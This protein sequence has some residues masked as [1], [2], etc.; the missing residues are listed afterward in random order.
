MRKIITI[1]LFIFWSTI[2]Y[3]LEEDYTKFWC[4]Q[5]KGMVEV[6]LA[7]AT[8]CDCLTTTHSIEVDYANKFYE[9][10][11]QSLHYSIMTKKLPGI[12]LLIKDT[13]DNVY[14]ARLKNIIIK[15]KLPITVWTLKINK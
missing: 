1:L 15:Y 2:S 6:K 13:G 12:L 9:A 3:A 7:D 5:Q 11:G 10:V 8:R 14:L 4:A